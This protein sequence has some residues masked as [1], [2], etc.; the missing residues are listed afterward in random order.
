M[1]EE[2]DARANKSYMNRWMEKAEEE[3]KLKQALG[4]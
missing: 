1:R 3:A 2:N 4:L